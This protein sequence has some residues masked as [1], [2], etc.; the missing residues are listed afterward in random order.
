MTI[1][2]THPR[3]T[4]PK[5]LTLGE[6][7]HGDLFCFVYVPGS[8][9]QGGILDTPAIVTDEYDYVYLRN[10]TILNI[11]GVNDPNQLG[12]RSRQVRKISCQVAWDW[13]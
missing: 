12:I 9:G 1:T 7:K 13:E 5:R 6:L 8:P 10:G 3:L 11:P 2:F 4:S